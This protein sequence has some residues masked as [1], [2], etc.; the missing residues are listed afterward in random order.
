MSVRQRVTWRGGMR[1]RC[2]TGLGVR[3]ACVQVRWCKGQAARACV[4]AG[5]ILEACL[6]DR[7]G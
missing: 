6:A 5:E 7:T 1:W 3:H 4:R 2:A